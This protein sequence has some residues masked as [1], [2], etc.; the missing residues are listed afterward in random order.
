MENI[1]S[2]TNYL[3]QFDLPSE[4]FQNITSKTNKFCVII[5][6]RK[7]PLLILVIKNFMYLLQK[8]NWG[9]IIWHGTENEEYIKDGLKNWP[10]VIF[11][12]LNIHNLQ[13]HELNILLTGRNFWEDNLALGVEHMI[14]FQTDTLLLKDNVDDFLQYDY[15]GAPWAHI[16]I[17][18]GGNGG[19]SLRKVKTML[20]IVNNF[21]FIPSISYAE[22]IYFSLYLVETSKTNNNIKLPLLEE[23]KK[24]SIETIFYEDPVGIHK[25]YQWLSTEEKNNLDNI[26]NNLRKVK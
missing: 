14:F 6:P 10:N 7:H 22:D 20:H 17:I 24:F 25:A 11:K 2:W 13:I 5:E 21:S 19:L 16:P 3:S 4:Y 1:K 23:A 26:L 15:I 12:N 8:H 18:G 9:L